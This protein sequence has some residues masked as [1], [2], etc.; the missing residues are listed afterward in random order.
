MS[1][2]HNQLA[3]MQPS[4]VASVPIDNSTEAALAIYGGAALAYYCSIPAGDTRR[5]EVL[6]KCSFAPDERLGD[7]VGSVIQLRHVYGTR[8]NVE[9]PT[10]HEIE[11]VAHTVLIDVDYKT[12]ACSSKGIAKSVAMLFGSRGLP[13][14]WMGPVPVQVIEVKARVG[15]ML[16]LRVLTESTNAKGKK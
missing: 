11:E 15:K 2:N 6:S 10:T 9:N 14:T 5:D 3:Q 4:S 13:N 16:C 8:I 7:V 12:Y 1:E